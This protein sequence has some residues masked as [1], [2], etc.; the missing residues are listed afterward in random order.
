M[1]KTSD[2][3]EVLS[4]AIARHFEK[5]PKWKDWEVG[6]TPWQ[7]YIRST[8][9]VSDGGFWEV[10]RD[11]E[12]DETDAFEHARSI[13]EPE[14]AMRLLKELLA[15]D[16]SVRG[17]FMTVDGARFLFAYRI[18]DW[19]GDCFVT[20]KELSLAIAEAVVKA[21]NLEVG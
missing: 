12:K 13:T 9:C 21:F 4:L 18:M 2:R 16:F 15:K 19:D 5:E 11:V 3:A 7:F 14:I 1:S 8:M 20:E 10:Y 17:S 6:E